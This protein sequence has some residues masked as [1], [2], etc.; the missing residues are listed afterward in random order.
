MEE[1]CLQIACSPNHSGHYPIQIPQCNKRTR[2]NVTTQS[3]L[4]ETQVQIFR[5]EINAYINGFPKKV[6]EKSN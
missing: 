4:E 5:T 2:I 1:E 3:I 6:L